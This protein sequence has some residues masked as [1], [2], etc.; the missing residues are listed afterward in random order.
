[1]KMNRWSFSVGGEVK[2]KR[3]VLMGLPLAANNNGPGCPVHISKPVSSVTGL[4]VLPNNYPAGHCILGL[5]VTG[6]PVLGPVAPRQ[7]IL[8][9]YVPP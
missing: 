7:C 6:H 4:R 1:M 8:G 2:E 9:F 3:F 5:G